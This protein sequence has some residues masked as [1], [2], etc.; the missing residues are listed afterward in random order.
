MLNTLL[1]DTNYTYK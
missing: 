1:M